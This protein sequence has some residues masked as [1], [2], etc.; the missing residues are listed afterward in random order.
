MEDLVVVS[1]ALGTMFIAGCVYKMV[2]I[3]LERNSLKRKIED[4]HMLVTNG[5]KARPYQYS[6]RW[7]APDEAIDR[8]FEEAVERQKE[9]DKR[10]RLNLP[11]NDYQSPVSFMDSE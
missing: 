7:T 4:I 11:S 8:Y 6:I 1:I 10:G 9:L 2:A 5:W 3:V